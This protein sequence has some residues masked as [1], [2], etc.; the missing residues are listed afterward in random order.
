MKTM[1]K[2]CPAERT[3]KRL[4]MHFTLYE[5]QTSWVALL[6]RAMLQNVWALNKE[7]VEKKTWNPV[8]QSITGQ[9]DITGK[10]KSLVH[11]E[12]IGKKIRLKGIAFP[13]RCKARRLG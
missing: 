13:G 9:R 11:E 5:L 6:N 4:V 1:G 12:Q 8:A 10:R 7:L 2:G 3:M